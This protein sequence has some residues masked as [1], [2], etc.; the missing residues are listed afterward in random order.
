MLNL[1]HKPWWSVKCWD[2]LLRYLV[3]ASFLVPS[4][5]GHKGDTTSVCVKVAESCL[6]LCNPMD[7]SPPGSSVLGISQARILECV[8]NPFSR[9]FSR[10][11][12]WTWVSCIAGRVFTIWATRE[13]PKTPLVPH[14]NP[15]KTKPFLMP[16]YS[17]QDTR[18]LP[19]LGLQET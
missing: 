3:A 1:M 9:G 17:K 16:S 12:D 2:V 8:A 18:Q 10:P 13:A 11:R 19:V 7:S 5:H 15:H 14:N 6:T 4:D